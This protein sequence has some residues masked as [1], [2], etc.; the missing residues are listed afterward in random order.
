M[1]SAA[2]PKAA[3]PLVKQQQLASEPATLLNTRVLRQ[4]YDACLRA[5]IMRRGHAA[6]ATEAILA[7]ASIRLQAGDMVV[8]SSANAIVER[9]RSGRAQAG[10]QAADRRRNLVAADSSGAALGIATGLALA[11]RFQRGSNVVLCL[12]RPEGRAVED[13]HEVM[14]QAGEMDLPIVYVLDASRKKVSVAAEPFGFP[15]V[16]VDAGDP[17]AVYRVT[18]EAIKRARRRLGSTLIACIP[19]KKIDALALLESYLRGSRHWSESWAR[20]LRQKYERE[21]GGRKGRV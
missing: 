7:G 9:L 16:N 19:W 11:W 15:T 10:P 17:I 6:A 13:W 21:L 18:E 5:R 8:T 20:E 1:P 14:R 12:S 3:D 2:I 4:L